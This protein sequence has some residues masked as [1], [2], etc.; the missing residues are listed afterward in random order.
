MR[1]S[2]VQRTRLLPICSHAYS[3]T[4]SHSPAAETFGFGVP[5]FTEHFAMRM[6]GFGLDLYCSIAV[7]GGGGAPGNSC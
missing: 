1:F 6:E 2:D 5:A 3:P 4:C 7:W